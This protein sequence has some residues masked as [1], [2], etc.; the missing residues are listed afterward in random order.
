MLKRAKAENT[1]L[2]QSSLRQFPTRPKLPNLIEDLRQSGQSFQQN[3]QQAR[4]LGA[5][6]C[7]YGDAEAFLWFAGC[8]EDG[9]FEREEVE[10]VGEV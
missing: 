3:R 2:R 5:T 7:S 6:C 4:S 10:G 9:C 1:Y 8:G